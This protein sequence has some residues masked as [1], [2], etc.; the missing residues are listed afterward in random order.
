MTCIGL[1]HYKLL[2][3]RCFLSFCWAPQ[4]K[5][6]MRHFVIYLYIKRGEMAAHFV[7]IAMIKKLPSNMLATYK[8]L[9]CKFGCEPRAS[10]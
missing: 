4:R 1:G 2:I 8:N 10:G 5:Q 6:G 9:K 7:L 3:F